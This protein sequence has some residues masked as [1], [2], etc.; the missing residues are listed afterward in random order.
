MRTVDTPQPGPLTPSRSHI[1]LTLPFVADPPTRHHTHT[2]SPLRSLS[3]RRSPRRSLPTRSLHSLPPLAPL[4]LPSCI[5]RKMYLAKIG[6]FL[7]APFPASD[8]WRTV[9]VR[10]ELLRSMLNVDLVGFL[11][12]EV[13]SAR[14]AERCGRAALRQSGATADITRICLPLPL[15]SSAP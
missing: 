1:P 14:E 7:H 9:A 12:F 11:M 4:Q 5:V 3:P 2:P 13:S 8:V 10:L 6:F 15:C